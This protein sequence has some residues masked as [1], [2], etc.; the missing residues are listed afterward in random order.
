MIQLEQV[1]KSFSTPAGVINAIENVTLSV[2]KGQICGVIGRSGAGKSTL[3]RCVNLLERP[4]SGRVMIDGQDLSALSP[5]ALRQVRHQ[6]G[7]VFQHFNLLSSRT[8]YQNIAF[9]LELLGTKKVE[10]EQ[11]V[12]PLLELTGLVDKRDMYPSALSGGQKQRVAIARALVTQPKVLLCDEMTS[13]LDPE[14]TQ[15]IIDLVKQINKEMGVTI[16][17]ITHEMEV[18]KKLA[19]HVA[20]IDQGRLVEEADVLTLFRS[21]LTEVAQQLVQNDLQ[22][23]I[24]VALRQQIQ[25]API[26]GG[27]QLIQVSFIG[28][29]ATQPMIEAFIQHNDVHVNILQANLE[30]LRETTIGTMLIGLTGAHERCLNAVDYLRDQGLDVEELGYVQ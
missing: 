11:R 7:M 28:E 17:F 23:R 25:S 16:L 15:S 9:Q 27:Q 12:V 18:V 2:P 6:I 22:G 24:P 1:S 14:T 5:R 13:A 19:D 30:Y 29:V 8:V 21:P 4:T 10:I 26:D 3:V 20:V